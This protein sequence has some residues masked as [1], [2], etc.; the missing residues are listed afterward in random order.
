MKSDAIE[1]RVHEIEELVSSNELSNATKLL[2]DFVTDFSKNRAHRREA[3]NIKATFT[4]LRQDIRNYGMDHRI[5]VRRRELIDQVLRF[6]YDVEEHY[7]SIMLD[8]LNKDTEEES[9]S[10]FESTTKLQE[11]SVN[12]YLLRSGTL[13]YGGPEMH[14]FFIS[15]NKADRN[16]AEWI[17]WTLEEAGYSVVIQAWDFRPGGNFVLEMQKAAID[18]HQTIAVLSENYLCAEY[19]HPEWAAAFAR[20][21]QGHQRTLIPMRV[22]VCTP[23]GLLGSII[24]V[25]LVG[26]SEQDARVAILGAFSGRAKPSQAPLFPGESGEAPPHIPQRVVSEPAPYP[27]TSGQGNV[28][29]TIMV[30]GAGQTIATASVQP[31][32][33][34]PRGASLSTAERLALMHTL[35]GLAPQQLNMLIFAL[36]PPPGLIHP[37]PAAQGDR[38]F[39]L[40]SWAAGPGGCGVLKVHQILEAILHPH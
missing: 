31:R 24:Y 33:T 34:P 21:P 15:Y 36:D 40:L 32:L 16:W 37:M 2:I 29:D 20:D 7:K 8:S 5:E 6:L 10:D 17:A 39:A 3:I 38:T 12:P 18:T 26:L 11:K 1:D 30:T 13:H 23:S 9:I 28:T 27:G 19:T 35:N 25:D 4:T 14:D 22:Q